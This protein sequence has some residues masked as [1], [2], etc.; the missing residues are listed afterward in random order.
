ML[1]EVIKQFKK[2]LK[3]YKLGVLRMKV[4]KTVKLFRCEDSKL[5]IEEQKGDYNTT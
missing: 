1:D 2:D 4:V 3:V 5:V